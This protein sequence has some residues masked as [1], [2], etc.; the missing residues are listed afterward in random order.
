MAQRVWSLETCKFE[1]KS[2]PSNSSKVSSSQTY[3]VSNVLR[4]QIWMF[5]NSKGWEVNVWHETQ[6]ICNLQVSKFWNTK[7]WNVETYSVRCLPVVKTYIFPSFQTL[8]VSKLSD[9]WSLQRFDPTPPL[10]FQTFERLEVFQAPTSK[11]QQQIEHLK[12]H[13]FRN[14]ASLKHA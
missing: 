2:T 3:V 1:N 13:D 9:F 4:F 10:R 7:T 12:I 14:R 5:E 11:T 8:N 6:C